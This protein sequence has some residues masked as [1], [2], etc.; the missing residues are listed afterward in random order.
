[1]KSII[2]SMAVAAGL[3][4]AGSAMAVDM[5]AI[6]KKNNCTACHAIDKKVV[7]PAW[8]E[9]SKKYKGDATAEAKLITKVSKGGAGVWGSMPMPANDPAG[10]KQ[11]DIKEL[12]DF[13]LGLAK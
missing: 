4:I 9:V 2:V 11:A 10:K 3:L 13:V 1:M 6:A 7:G 5:P 12:V 8:M